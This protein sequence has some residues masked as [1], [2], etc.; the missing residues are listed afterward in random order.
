VEF[1]APS[2][3]EFAKNVAK[4]MAGGL[5]QM[6]EVRML[7]YII[8]VAFVLFIIAFTLSKCSGGG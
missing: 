7:F 8:P 6:T 2:E 1:K 5:T 3:A 4:D